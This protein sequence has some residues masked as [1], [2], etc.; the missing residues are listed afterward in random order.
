MSTHIQIEI[1]HHVQTIC[2]IALSPDDRFLAIGGV[3]GKITIK[4]LQEV[5]LLP[6]SVVS[7]SIQ[8]I[9]IYNGG[10]TSDSPSMLQ[11]NEYFVS[12]APFINV[13]DAALDSWKQDRLTEAES[14]LT[15]SIANSD[16]P[17]HH[18]LANRAL[19][20][21]R[22][23]QCIMALEDAER[24]IKIRP[25]TIGYI[26]KSTALMGVGKKSEGC[27]VYDLAFTRCHPHYLDFLL[28]IKA[29]VLFVAGRHDDAMSRVDD[30][31][32]IA[33][34]QLDLMCC[35]VQAYMH[36]HLGNLLME[37]NEYN[38]AVHSFQHA[39]AQVRHYTGQPLVVVSLISGWRFDNLGI[40][41][42][43][44][45]CEA[46][47]ATGCTEGASE[48]LLET[49]N[50]VDEKVYM[51]EPTVR[52]ISDF[53]R[54]CLSTSEGD[55]GVVSKEASHHGRPSK[56]FQPLVRV[57]AKSTLANGSWKD[58]LA[59]AITF[60][61]SRF[62]IYQVI[63]EHLE[64]IDRVTEASECFCQ[65]FYE[66]EEQLDKHQ[67]WAL[68][69]KHR[70]SEKLEHIGDNAMSAERYDEA[71]SQYSAAVSLGPED[72]QSLFI[73][74]SRAY[75]AGGMWESASNDADELIALTPDSPWGYERKHAALHTAR[76]Y[77]DAI[78]ALEVML[79]KMSQS[80]DP[81]IRERRHQYV[82]PEQTKAAICSAI[83]ESIRDSPR[84]LIHITSGRLLDKSKQAAAFEALLVYKEL[85]SSMTTHIEHSRIDDEV[86]QY[87]RY[88]MFSHKWEDNEPLFH[89][90]V[91]TNVYD[92]QRL[93]THDKLQMF[94]KIARGAGF[95]WAWSDTCC[96]DKSDHFVLQEALVAM[97]RWYE[98]SAIT[99]VFLL[100][101]H[102]PSRRGDLIQSIW[103]TRAWTFQEYHASK[104]VRFYA[105]D[106]TPYLNLDV[107]NHK[108]SPEIIS[109]MEEATGIS[110]R[111]LMTLRP[112]LDDIREK[113]CLASE[114]KTTLIED[115]AYS[116]LGIFSASLPVVYGEGDKALGRL[117]AQLLTSS[118]DTNILA[119]TGKSGSFNS[120]LPVAVPVFKQLATT[121]V[122]SNVQHPK[123][124]T[125]TTNLQASVPNMRLVMQLYERLNE[126]PI[127]FFVGQR[128]KLPCITFKLD[129]LSSSRGTSGHIFRAKAIGLGAV[130][131]KT[132][133]DLT[134][135]GS[136]VLVHPWID[137]LLDRHPV[138]GI[139]S[140]TFEENSNMV[141][142]SSST[143]NMPP[144]P[145]PSDTA[146]AAKQTRTLSLV[147]R[148][149]RP[150][151]SG[152]HTPPRDMASLLSPSSMP[153]MERQNQALRFIARLSQRF[154]SLLFT[155][156][157]QNAAEY[158]R[159]AAESMITVQVEI[160]PVALSKLVDGVRVL[161]VL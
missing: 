17:S 31:R 111:A 112:G 74:R 88:A 59:P 156:T 139:A 117:L 123:M 21:A 150:F 22:L 100:G 149:G 130:E 137:F 51:R 38:D 58:V 92:L 48:S 79:S 75:V 19:I 124:D 3:D 7:T 52:W 125:I 34:A 61:A 55:S 136:L 71:I 99:I 36:L 82:H 118:G 94:C 64:A 105:E 148:L 106:W 5:L 66:L 13:S 47:Y 37:C 43:Q 113:L 155:P 146:P 90:V 16:H 62:T 15:M 110:A 78:D 23:Q 142:H 8:V 157:R 85:L 86:Q 39:Q 72:P 24:S 127:A 50:L 6:H 40:T 56:S 119:W 104:T 30:L 87:Y 20:R 63:C 95:D 4:D 109:E 135:L 25:S 68:D 147:S 83:Q 28:L 53:T 116:L 132:T 45:L 114:R 101:V 128:M 159:V 151:A 76:N 81:E 65:M 97:F 44:R 134:R 96:I 131:I 29:V 33:N 84:V 160:T 121:H 18:A 144:F 153:L 158:R 138:G 69:F 41:I 126:L 54:R 42:R 98:G 11:T 67:E 12:Q 133:E 161:D 46:L 32:V 2:S 103:N 108:D 122:P 80:S 120:C 115:A 57:W 77:D 107:A 49:V 143:G 145:G 91:H 27:R 102:S 129:P 14:F 89:Q 140:P 73:K 35:I 9:E 141:S 154:G 152:S 93:P 70:C 26:A 10:R 1:I 60:T